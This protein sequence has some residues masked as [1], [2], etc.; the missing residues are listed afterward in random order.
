MKKLTAFALFLLGLSLSPTAPAQGTLQVS[1][2]GQTPT[3]KTTV[4]SDS[5][6][7]QSFSLFVTDPTVYKLDAVQLLMNPAS[8]NP[9]GFSVS[10]YDNPNLNSMTPLNFLGNL[11]GPDPS[12][13]GVFTYTTP[14]ITIAAGALYFVVITAATPIAQGSDVWSAYIGGDTTGATWSID[15]V[16]ASSTNGSTW[17]GHLRQNVFQMAL[18]T[19]PTPEPGTLA[20]AGLGLACLSFHRRRR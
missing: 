2:L 5:W 14:G 7:A 1:N 13:G 4:G 3:T 15:D 8:G 11:T 16:Y 10:I 12:A 18:Y 19:P 20:L 9:S 6:I 17:T